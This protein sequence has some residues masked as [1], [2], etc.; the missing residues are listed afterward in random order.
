MARYKVFLCCPSE[1]VG[2]IW[3]QAL[4]ASRTGIVVFSKQTKSHLKFN[5]F[6]L[7]FGCRQGLETGSPSQREVILSQAQFV[8]V[9]K[10][11]AIFS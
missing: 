3:S 2:R 11:S 7:A 10:Q 9:V 8:V 6:N 5:T 1:N 4:K